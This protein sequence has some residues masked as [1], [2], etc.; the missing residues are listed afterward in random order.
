MTGGTGAPSSHEL[1]TPNPHVHLLCL[2][3]C[4]P[5]ATKAT[6]RHEASSSGIVGDKRGASSSAHPHWTLWRQAHHDLRGP[7]SPAIMSW[8]KKPH[9]SWRWEWGDKAAGAF[10]PPQ[11]QIFSRDFP[12]LCSMKDPTGCIVYCTWA[13][14]CMDLPTGHLETGPFLFSCPKLM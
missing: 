7:K 8:S 5:L 12:A 6:Y 11:Q 14:V 1:Q 13:S 4:A 2:W 9:T 10:K 3:Q